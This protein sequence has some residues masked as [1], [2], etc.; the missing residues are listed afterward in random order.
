VARNAAKPDPESY[1]YC[2]VRPLYSLVFI[3]PMLLAFQ[4]GAAYYF[5]GNLLATHHLKRVLEYFGATAA[6]LPAVLVATVLLIQHLLRKDPWQLRPEVFA[7]MLGES[8]LWMCPLAVMMGLAGRL[9]AGGASGNLAMLDGVLQAFGAGIYEEFI[10]RLTLISLVLLVL[11]DLLHLPKEPMAVLAVLLAGAAFSLY[12][13]TTEE[14]RAFPNLPWP[15]VV[16]RAAAGAYLG[17]LYVCRGFG[18]TV[19]AHALYNVYALVAGHG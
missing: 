10:F 13:L 11:V 12:H 16:F 9:Q 17:A 6:L 1:R 2:T 4:V 5:G 18:I 7:G 3:L 8:I 19:G 14:I 15:E